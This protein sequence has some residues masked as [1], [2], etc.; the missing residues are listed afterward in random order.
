MGAH[1]YRP[2]LQQVTDARSRI[3]ALTPRGRDVL[4]G[5]LAG[6]SN[7][8]I[9]HSLGISPRTVEI[10]RARLMRDLGAHHVAEVIRLAL[11]AGF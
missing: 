1:T 9:A 4:N 8:M 6:R 7:K 11:Q 3:A 5:L 10:H 2:F